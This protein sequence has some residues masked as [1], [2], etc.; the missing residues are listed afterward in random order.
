[1]FP[2][3]GAAVRVKPSPEATDKWPGKK[4]AE[5]ISIPNKKQADQNY[6]ELV[7]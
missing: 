7:E 3:A 6:P 4:D 5:L 2:T 1:V